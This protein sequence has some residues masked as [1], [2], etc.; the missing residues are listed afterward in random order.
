MSWIDDAIAARP[1]TTWGSH[2]V[3]E[4][5]AYGEKTE[6][7]FERAVRA[8]VALPY[9][10][11]WVYKPCEYV[12]RL[13]K[14]GRAEQSHLDWAR[15]LIAQALGVDVKRVCLGFGEECFDVRPY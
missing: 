13:N 11:C 1:H 8:D 5:D 2:L 15:D 4:K 3:V 10:K 9:W 6:V 12:Y 7:A 14:D